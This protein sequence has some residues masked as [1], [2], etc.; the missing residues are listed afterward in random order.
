MSIWLRILHVG[1]CHCR[2]EALA[3]QD[4]REKGV[5][6]TLRPGTAA[7]SGG[8][9]RAARAEASKACTERSECDAGVP[10][11][12]SILTCTR[13]KEPAPAVPSLWEG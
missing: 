13:E 6:L 1:Q 10:R 9:M 11:D 7:I 8:S 12:A 5:Y 4:L 3:G 2:L